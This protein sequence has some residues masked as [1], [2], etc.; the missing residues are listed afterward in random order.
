MKAMADSGTR[1]HYSIIAGLP[2]VMELAFYESGGTDKVDLSSATFMFNCVGR[3][4]GLR[5]ECYVEHGE[6]GI[7]VLYLPA[8]EVDTYDYELTAESRDGELSVVLYGVLTAIESKFAADLV[9]DP[10]VGERRCLQVTVA[11][12][13]AKPLKLRW[14]AGS[15][16]QYAAYE[17]QVM[18]WAMDNMERRVKEYL[19]KVERGVLRR[20]LVKSYD[21]I[22]QSGETCTGGV[23]YYDQGHVDD[24]HVYLRADDRVAYLHVGKKGAYVDVSHNG[25]WLSFV[26][27]A[28]IDAVAYNLSRIDMLTAEVVDVCTIK[29]TFTG[30]SGLCELEL[31][32]VYDANKGCYFKG[33]AGYVVYAWFENEGWLPVDKNFELEVQA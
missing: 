4:T 31:H 18:R 27:S 1:F 5:E 16:A 8:L 11:N 10:M 25:S 17:A 33:H 12:D 23:Y 19:G 21:K 13:A 6:S 3:T 15:I 9:Q 24:E 7:L 26:G 30:E 14:L 20:I 29:I 32:P 28:N 2:E 22:P